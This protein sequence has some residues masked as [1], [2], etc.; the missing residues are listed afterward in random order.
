[1]KKEIKSDEYV[2]V[3]EEIENPI[4]NNEENKNVLSDEFDDVLFG[5]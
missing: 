1:M 4:N 2:V 5:M 3:V